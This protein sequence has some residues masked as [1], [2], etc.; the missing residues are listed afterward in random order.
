M[1]LSGSSDCYMDGELQKGWWEVG[2]EVC[3]LIVKG[4]NAA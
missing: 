2:L 4:L 1:V 3:D